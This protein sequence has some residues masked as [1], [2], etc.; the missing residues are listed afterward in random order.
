MKI[1]HPEELVDLKSFKTVKKSRERI[2]FPETD[3]RSSG[4]KRVHR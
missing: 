1:G 3:R 4:N 2:P